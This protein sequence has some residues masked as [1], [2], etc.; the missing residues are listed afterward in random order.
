[1]TKVAT[2]NKIKR[3]NL[4]CLLNLPLPVTILKITGSIATKTPTI[5][6]TKTKMRV[7]SFPESTLCSKNSF[8]KF[9]LLLLPNRF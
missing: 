3:S 8:N 6:K 1:M 4:D 2:K 5:N 9:S 7:K